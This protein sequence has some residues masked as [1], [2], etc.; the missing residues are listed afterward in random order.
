MV[1]DFAALYKLAEEFEESARTY[2][3]GELPIPSSDRPIEVT[4][5]DE[6]LDKFSWWASKVA[7]DLFTAQGLCGDLASIMSSHEK[8]Q[9]LNIDVFDRFARIADWIKSAQTKYR[10]MMRNVD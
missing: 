10:A 9:I 8:D 3:S 7:N 6:P 4:V 1:V 5:L 2:R